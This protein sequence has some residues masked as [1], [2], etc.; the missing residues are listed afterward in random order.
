MAHFVVVRDPDP[1]RKNRYLDRVDPFLRIIPGLEEGAKDL[2]PYTM[3]WAH[4]KGAPISAATTALGSCVVI[5]DVL[6]GHGSPQTAAHSLLTT[7]GFSQVGQLDGFHL[8]VAY[9]TE[10]TLHVGVDILG[11][12]PVYYW[13]NDELLVISSSPEIIRQHP[14]FDLTIDGQGLAGILLFNGLLGGRTLARGL[15]RLTPGHALVASSDRT[16][17]EQRFVPTPIPNL[18]SLPLPRQVE[19]ADEVLTRVFERHLSGDGPVGFLMSGG[20]DSRT[21]AGYLGERGLPVHAVTVGLPTDLEMICAKRVAEALGFEHSGRERRLDDPAEAARTTARMEWLSS[22]FSGAGGTRSTETMPEMTQRVIS[23]H[24]FDYVLTTSHGDWKWVAGESW[25]KWI[26]LFEWCNR[27]GIPPERIKTMVQESV[28][29]DGID[30]AMQAAEDEFNRYS[31]SGVD[32]LRLFQLYNRGR[33]HVGG[34]LWRQAFTTWPVLPVLDRSL[35]NTAWGLPLNAVDQDRLLQRSL[36][37]KR[38]PR[39][40]RMPFDKNLRRTV[41][42][43]PTTLQLLMRGFLRRASAFWPSWAPRKERRQYYRSFD[44]NNDR[45]VSVRRAA[46]SCRDRWG[47][48]FD[49]DS[50]ATFLPPPDAKVQVTD[51][52]AGVAGHKMLV[53]LLLWLDSRNPADSDPRRV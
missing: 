16:V 30:E 18:G 53:G 52:I 50:L 14:R 44:F 39:I 38:F 46:E 28:L 15:F 19:V 6:L 5:G 43:A 20:M 25:P 47:D 17:E 32:P 12:F 41:L 31:T 21:I 9:S 34:G 40:A 45:W 33:H 8:V 24:V 42:L 11:L 4:G 23:G 27:W 22:G 29:G 13:H 10:G 3:A 35:L 36:L 2:G 51:P 48:V 37:L 7:N 1:E 26:D 49:L